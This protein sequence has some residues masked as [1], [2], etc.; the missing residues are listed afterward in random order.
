VALIKAAAR[1]IIREH[2]RARF[3]SPVLCLGVPDVYLTGAELRHE[4]RANGLGDPLEVRATDDLV[5]AATFFDALG[6]RE[7]TSVDI[8]GAHLTPDRIHDLNTPLPSDLCD[9]FGLVVDPGTT[10]HVFDV[11]TALANVVGALRTGGAVIH[12]VPIYS[13]NGGYFSINPNVLHDFYEANGFVDIRAFVIMWDRYH[14]AT[15]RSR[16]YPYTDVMRSRHAIADHDQVRFSPELLFFAR[17]ARP[18]ADIAVP[19]QH[20]DR[21]PRTPRLSGRLARRILG[22][23]RTVFLRESLYRW[24]QLRRSRRESFWV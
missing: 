1:L 15:G 20:E 10:E 24:L 3:A 21:V 22:E 18:V 11:R 13:Y 8:P 23:G 12:L 7:R 6:L 2:A 17:K 5:D 19:I 14:A 9:R 16:V 4:L